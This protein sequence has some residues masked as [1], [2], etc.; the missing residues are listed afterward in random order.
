MH[1]LHRPKGDV[2]RLYIKRRNGGGGLVQLMSAYSCSM[3]N[4][5][6]YIEQD[7]GRFCRLLKN[8]EAGK[9]NILLK[10]AKAIK[11][12]Y[13]LLSTTQ[14]PAKVMLKDSTEEERTE[15]LQEKPMHGQFFA[16]SKNLLSTK[17]QVVL[18]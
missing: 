14:T 15:E 4:L 16:A 7:K 18:G 6:D 12:K 3:V 2:R 8:H 5:S 17:K 10:E 1:G 9:E 11:N 13:L